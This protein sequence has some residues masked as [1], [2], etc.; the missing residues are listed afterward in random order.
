MGPLATNDLIGWDVMWKARKGLGDMTMHTKMYCGP[1]DLMDRLCEAGHFG[2]KSGHGV[3]K[4]TEG[5]RQGSDE[6]SLIIKEIRKQKAVV[7]RKIPS[8]E[9][10]KRLLYGMINE[11][12]Q[13]LEEGKV[14]RPSDIEVIFVNGY[15]FPKVKGGPMWAADNLFGLPEV[16]RGLMEFDA[17]AARR[18]PKHYS[19]VDHFRPCPL[20]EECVRDGLTLDSLWKKREKT[21]SKL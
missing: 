21:P 3:Y 8:A 20:L 14:L 2:Q 7:P 10:Q 5:K 4:Y 17:A 18:D 9:A 16:L 1:F 15:G 12:F 6:T 13:L 19:P 11:G